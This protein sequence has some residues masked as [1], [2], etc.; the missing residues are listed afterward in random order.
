VTINNQKLA[1]DIRYLVK[2]AI[3]EDLGSGDITAGLIDPK[4][5]SKA[6]VICRDH[7]VVAGT[8]W[9]DEVF[10]QLDVGV[11]IH[12]LVKDGDKVEPNTLLCHLEG[13]ST[14]LLSGERTALNLLQTLSATAT[15]TNEYVSK[16]SHTNCKILD[17]RKTIPG[18]REAQ[19]Y[20]VTCGGGNNHRHGLYDGV[21]IKENHILAAGSINNAVSAAKSQNQNIA[22]EVEVE[23]LDELQ[24]AINSGAD[25]AL[26]DN[27]GEAMLKQAVEINQKRIK[28]EA[29]G[30]ISL[31]NVTS[32]AETG[33]DYISI[34]L[35]T[36]NINAVDLSMRFQ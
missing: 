12:W 18:L 9:F 1:N 36:K 16:V 3:S 17:T 10:S 32:I 21:L 7:A 4:Q 25:I 24:E 11:K 26:L 22:I 30:G 27:M 31:D 34:G 15:A 33:V 23:N 35:I 6:T 8:A 28:L 20:A 29:S 14:S 5:S 13:F 2:T 19:K